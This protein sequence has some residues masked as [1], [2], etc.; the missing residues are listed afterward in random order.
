MYKRQI[1]SDETEIEI[2]VRRHQFVRRPPNKRYEARYVTG[3]KRF[4]PSIMLWGLNIIENL[5]QDLKLKVKDRNPVNVND[6]WQYCQEEFDNIS[7][8]Y[9]KK[10]YKS[11]P[12]RVK[13]VVTAKEGSRKR[14]LFFSYSSYSVV[15]LNQNILQKIVR[16]S[17]FL[18]QKY[19]FLV[20]SYL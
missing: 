15:L 11:L 19:I 12:Q 10:L 14:L 18:F 3:T 6:L 16:C 8:E 2:A 1:F 13:F 4:S 9:V 17:L 20:A 5:W 7:D